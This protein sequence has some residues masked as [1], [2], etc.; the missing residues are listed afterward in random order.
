MVLCLVIVSC[1]D[2]HNDKKLEAKIPFW[3]CSHLAFF[4]LKGPVSRVV[5]ATYSLDEDTDEENIILDMCFN[6][7]GQIT[8][9]NPTDIVPST[10]DVWQTIAQYSYEYDEDGKLIKVI[11]TPLES[12]P[13]VYTL[14]YSGHSKYVPL[15]FSLGKIDFFL[16]QGLQSITR[17]DGAISY[18]YDGEKAV[19]EENTWSGDKKTEYLYES[20]SLYPTKK[21][22]T[23]SRGET[24]LN[25]ETTIYTYDIEG[26]LLTQDVRTT[27]DGIESYRT[28]I[29]YVEGKSLLPITKKMDMGTNIFD[30]SYTYDSNN[31]L[32]RVQYIENEASEDEITDKE[33]Y[34]YISYDTYGN[35]TESKQLQSSLVDWSHADGTI[36][37]RR[38]FTY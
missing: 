31:F 15:I 16:V 4:G 5:E 24:I 26:R 14:Q 36:G 8:Y 28:I 10:Q 2:E 32:Q 21:V 13:L 27:E 30:W 23:T 34:T 7:D 20:G 12:E 17:G 3:E 18:L 29:R 6:S 38:K 11:V 37:V 33:E 25:E 9:Y 19:Y 1:N 35:W 22:V